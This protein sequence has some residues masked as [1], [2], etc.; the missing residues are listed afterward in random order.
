MTKEL[1]RL[2][3]CELAEGIREKR[4]SCE[5]VMASVTERMAAHNPRLN[6]VVDDYTDEALAAARDADRTLASGDAVG[7]L[8][9]VPITIKSNI[10]VAGKRTPN[11]L[12]H[13]ADLI[14]T[15][16]SPVVSNLKQA[17]A[18]IIGRT[19]TPELS[20]RM[21]TDNPLHGRTLNPWDAEASPGGSSGGASSAAAAG[22]GPIHHGNDIGGSLRFPSFNCG[23]ATVKPT[24]GR[25][26]AYL[27]SAPAERGMLSQLMSVPGVICREVRDVRLGTRIMAQA[28]PR[29]PFWMPVP[30]DGWPQEP[31]PLRVGVATESY[32]HPVHPE[33]KAA[34]ERAADYLA[35][36]GYMVEPITTPSVD[37]A[38]QCWFRYL[39]HELETYL[40]PLVRE[41]GSATIQQI[42]EWYFQ[43]GAVAT[44]EEYRDGIKQRSAMTRE[45]NVLLDDCPLIL[46]PFYMQP[47]PEWDCD[48]QSF[49]GTQAA[50]NA[51]IYSTGINWLGLPAGI[52]PTGLV[53]N[54]PA[55]IQLIGRRFRE[56]LILDAMEQVEAQ[57]GVLTQQL[58]A[59]PDM[60]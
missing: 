36:A 10:D 46:S 50:F 34:V 21:T 14:A 7:E 57:V 17:G 56:D 24:F 22:F 11:G 42:F 8:H 41:H 28:D 37:D 30:F 18:I 54:R 9:G 16:D 27:P 1:W 12:P 3:A 55:G 25:V 45:W 35:D 39:G 32:G 59:R 40:M 58:W 44:P 26:P 29:D 43:M 6:A 23:L 51:A 19:N 38:A 5:A 49:A 53:E 60:A 13:F 20:M 2:S 52:V 4:F 47:T 31:E 33:I 15:E 48:A